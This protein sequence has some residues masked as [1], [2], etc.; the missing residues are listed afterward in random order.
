MRTVEA[1]N[2]WQVE[3]LKLVERVLSDASRSYKMGP[4]PVSPFGLTQNGL[5]DYRGVALAEPVRYLRVSNVDF[6]DAIVKDGYRSRYLYRSRVAM[7]RGRPMP[8]TNCWKKCRTPY[9]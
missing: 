8:W 9:R 1:R 2:R 5:A 3:Q 7:P 4:M 6:S